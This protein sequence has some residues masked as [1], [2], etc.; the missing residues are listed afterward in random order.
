MAVPYIKN[1]FLGGELSPQLWGRTETEKYASCAS[2]MRNMYVNYRG[3]ANSRAGTAF[4][5]YSKQTGQSYPPRLISFQFNINQGLMLE[6]GNEYMRVISDGAYVTDVSVGIT[7]IT[8]ANPA[9]VSATATGAETVT[10]VDS[11]VAQSY[12]PGEV[13][14]MAGG[15]Y[16]MPAMVQVTNTKLLSVQVNANGTG[17]AP[18]DT[19]NLSGGTQT[20]QAVATVA[21]TEVVALPTIVAG[22]T[23]GTPGTATVTGTTGTGTKFQA[24][25]TITGSQSASPN[26]GGVTASYAPGDTVT[27]AGGTFT[28]PAVLSVTSTELLSL[29]GLTAGTGYA[30]GNTIT[31][32]GGSTTAAPVVTISTTKV[33]SVPTIASGGTGGTPGAV[34]LTGTTGTGTKFQATGT[35][36]SG[37]V[38]TAITALTVAGSYTVNPTTLSAEPVTGGG[39]SGATLSLTM[40]VNTF[41]FTA[42]GAFSA[43]PTAGTFTQN[44]TSGSGTGATFTGLFG[45]DVVT[46]AS[47]GSYTAF[48]SN[49]VAQ[50]ATSGSGAGVTFTVSNLATI[51]AVN[52][53]TVAGSYTVNPTTPAAEPVTGGGL[54]GAELGLTMGVATVNVTS[55]GV[56]TAN[57][58]SGVFT[59]ASTSGSG[60]GASFYFGLFGPNACTVASPGSYSAFPS[61]PVAQASSTGTGL[62]ATF[63]FTSGATAAFSNGD[64]VY[65]S[66]IGGMTQ[67]NGRV[68]VVTSASSSGFAL[69]DVFGNN[70]NS[71]GYSTYTSG[72]VAAR[73]FT[74]TTPW[75]AVDLPYLKF[76]QSADVMSFCCWNQETLT[77]YPPYDLARVTDSSWTIAQP[78]IGAALAAPT[79]LT[80]TPIGSDGGSQVYIIWYYVTAVNGATG[81]ES[82]FVY[83]VQGN[84]ALGTPNGSG[85][86]PNNA[87][88]WPAVK[89]ATY[90][91]IY[92][93]S[94][95]AIQSTAPT[96]PPTYIAGRI[97]QTSTTSFVDTGVTPDYSLGPPQHNNPFSRGAIVSGNVTNGGGGYKFEGATGTIGTSTGSGGIVTPVN[98]LPGAYIG[99]I[100]IYNA[101]SNYTQGDTLTIN[102]NGS[103]GSGATAT[104]TIGPESGTY[105]GVVGYFQQRR[106]YAS[107]QNNP[108]TYWAS[109]TGLYLNFDTHFPTV[110]NDALTGSPWAIAVDGIQWLIAMPGGLIALTGRQAWQL[111]GPG[112]SS[113]NPQPITPSGQEAQPQMFNGISATVFPIRIDD[114]VIFVQSKGSIYRMFKYQYFY[115]I[116]TGN[117]ITE[118]STQL[119]IGHQIVQHAY[120]E[121]PYKVI[122]S[123][124]DDGILLSMTYFS[125]QQITSWARHDTN[126][127]F[128]GVA[129]ITELPVDAPYLAVERTINGQTSYMIERMDNRFW[130]VAEDVWAVDAGVQ[131]P[132]TYPAATLNVSSPTGTGSLTGVTNLVGGSGYASDTAVLIVDNNGLGPGAGATASVSISGGVITA[133]NFTAAGSGYIYPQISFVDPTN[134]G[135][136]A[137]CEAILNN[138][139]TITASA[140][141]F[142][143]NSVGDIIRTGGGIAVVTAYTSSTQVTGNIL[144]PI[145]TLYQNSGTPSGYPAVQPQTAGN[146]SMT[147]PTQTVTGLWHL[148]GVPVTGL[149]DGNVIPPQ[150]VSAQGTITLPAPATLIT[151]GLG[152]TAQ[153]QTAYFDAGPQGASQGRRKRVSAVTARIELSEGI[154]VGTNQPDGSTLSPP[155]IAPFWQGLTS[156]PNPRVP[157]YNYTV[158]PL[159]TGDVRIP[160]PGNYDTRGQVAFQQSNPL[161]MNVNAVVTEIMDGDLEAGSRGGQPAGGGNTLSGDTGFY[162]ALTNYPPS[163]GFTSP[164][165][166]GDLNVPINFTGVVYPAGQPVQI[167]FGASGS[168][169][170]EGGWTNTTVTQGTWSGSLTP[171]SSGNIYVWARQTNNVSVL[172]VVGPVN[173]LQPGAPVIVQ[174]VSLADFNTTQT[175]TLPNPVGIGNTLFLVTMVAANTPLSISGFT[176]IQGSS[177]QTATYYQN[178]TSSAQN[179]ATI[180]AF[181]SSGSSNWCA[182]LYE[183]S[184]VTSF[185]PYEQTGSAAGNVA[186]IN[187]FGATN[188][189]PSLYYGVVTSL[190]VTVGV[191]TQNWSAALPAGAV[192]LSCLYANADF[193]GTSICAGE[194]YLPNGNGT[195]NMSITSE[196]TLALHGPFGLQVVGTVV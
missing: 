171:T 40:G 11:A 50:A 56:F 180:P 190:G 61:N 142:T 195:Q 95:R 173:I 85:R 3:G 194:W 15:T 22:G 145:T 27:L 175:L 163:V 51:T 172:A 93:E 24:S 57:A 186:S 72:G 192:I 133:V 131:M 17:Y 144:V 30:P 149:A 181:G 9:V 140:A 91:N 111:T 154:L 106:F 1:S 88:S 36:S 25:V 60:T 102:A 33:S 158:S 39:L 90:Y 178:I 52:S 65:L 130:P 58:P 64:W 98:V 117:D 105:P 7:G 31:L 42:G 41:T 115:N 74:L 69:Q 38:L 5:G 13:A 6:F 174:H 122:W 75:A 112:G 110:N 81:E 77:E 48:P 83:T 86:T 71:T 43:N 155:Q 188:A 47:S 160:V 73:I 101:G 19:I 169:P 104:L 35:I 21:T 66:G 187:A 151:V 165:T 148:I 26:N 84:E 185:G 97:G 119:F 118:F 45:P 87:L 176:F 196:Q 134:S 164:P 116:Y 193:E 32:G 53:L 89:G 49:P 146:W 109:Q 4:V 37:G 16:S 191:P 167:A 108:D 127:N 166:T 143:A 183:I 137:S 20:S 113:Q 135:S 147:T 156:L 168:I 161:P 129:T 100:Y 55:A 132:L 8:K 12:A 10:P 141:V 153:L 82:G 80:V 179:S 150:V 189:A 107:T 124:R 96:Y 28:S 54:T 121:E 157:P 136:G 170:P 67:L 139:A 120:A 18:G 162:F 62:G 128:V 29:T 159:F 44:A 70:I 182:S 46:F 63:D 23:G 34:T 126:G 79:S 59:Q 92:A 177:T 68:A 123:V 99:S 14:T 125:V 76:T 114:E 78:A 2:T 184:G 138:S 152:F 94:P 103:G